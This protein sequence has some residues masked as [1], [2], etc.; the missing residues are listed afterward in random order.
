MVKEDSINDTLDV[1]RK[2]LEDDKFEAKNDNILILNRKVN[3]DGTINL[4]QKDTNEADEIK[5]IIDERLTNILETKVEQWFE[6]KIP[7]I[8]DKYFEKKKI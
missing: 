1:I 5:K 2:A 3:E 4:L 8:L 7:K 6:N